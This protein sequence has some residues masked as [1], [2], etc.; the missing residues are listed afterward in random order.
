MNIFVIHGEYKTKS[1]ERLGMYIN[2]AKE[3][4]WDIIKLGDNS[5]LSFSE[6]LSSDTLFAKGKLMICEDTSLL[7]K[8]NLSWLKRNTARFEGNFVVYSDNK[9][10]ESLLKSL[11][12]IKK[13]EEYKLP[14]TI[15]N[16]LDSFYPGNAQN[17]LVILHELAS[18]EPAEFIFSLLGK[19]LRDMYWVMASP[20]DIPYPSWRVDKL[21]R[22]ANKFKGDEIKKLINDLALIDIDV[23]T[24]KANLTDSLD[25]LIVTKLE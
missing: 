1:Y 23:K 9:L 19:H 5:N 2:K 24:S 14:R 17:S 10:S 11:E 16:F 25:L 7:T 13:I 8:T 6:A 22:Q 20:S 21:E 12:P 15:F 4:D 3:R 18:V